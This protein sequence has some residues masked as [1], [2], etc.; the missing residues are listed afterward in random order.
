M[1][2]VTG[3]DLCGVIARTRAA[4]PRRDADEMKTFMAEACPAMTNRL[5]TSQCNLNSPSIALSW[6][7]QLVMRHAHRVQWS[8]ELLHPERQKT[9][10]L[11]KFWKEIV[12]LPNVGL[13]QPAMIGTPIQDVRSRQA[14]TTDLS[15]EIF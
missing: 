5:A 11:G 8:L 14:I 1:P 3:I 2:K 6:F 10:Q 15:T 4:R 12:V 7:D 9:M 13:K